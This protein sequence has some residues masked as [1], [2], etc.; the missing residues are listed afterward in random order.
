MVSRYGVDYERLIA[1][2]YKDMG[3]PYKNLSS[4]EREILQKKLDVIHA[5]FVSEVARQRGLAE[6]DVWPLATGEYFLGVEALDLGLVDHLGSRQDAL[7]ALEVQLNV[8]DLRVVES[9]SS[10]GFL[11]YFAQSQAYAFGSGLGDAFVS[12]V[13]SVPRV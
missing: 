3:S 12:D 9:K 5:Y 8:T 13:S 10:K 2:K 11:S 6:E 7:D 4:T 1:G